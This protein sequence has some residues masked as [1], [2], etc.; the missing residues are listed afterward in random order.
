[1]RNAPQHPRRSVGKRWA[2]QREN[3]LAHITF[4]RFLVRVNTHVVFQTSRMSKTLL[5]HIA[6]I[7]FLVRV[8]THV[9]LQTTKLIKTRLAHDTFIRFLVR[10]NTL[11]ALQSIRM[12]KTLLAHIAFVRFLF[13]VRT[14]VA[15]QTTK[16]SKTLL[17]HIT[18]VRFFVRVNTHVC[19]QLG[20]AHE[21][22]LTNTALVSLLSLSLP[23]S[24]R[25][26]G[27][28]FFSRLILRLDFIIDIIIII[29]S[30]IRK[31]NNPKTGGRAS[32][33]LS[34]LVTLATTFVFAHSARS[35]RGFFSL[36]FKVC[37][38][39]KSIPCVS[40]VRSVVFPTHPHKRIRALKGALYYH[41][42]LR[43]KR[44]G[45]RRERE[46]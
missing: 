31:Q 4:V 20:R 42:R 2:K 22:L 38:C 33:S 19:G 17:A 44:V 27:R 12:T 1:M 29:S 39:Y 18:F 13:R 21:H 45:A 10:V 32:P 36:I 11:V 28:L 6:F 46:S 7:R 34:S 41:L 26:L 15:L 25:L 14:H 23:S 3:F 5:A 9:A 16:L 37:S 8:N 43:H 35:G 30:G 40:V 24:L